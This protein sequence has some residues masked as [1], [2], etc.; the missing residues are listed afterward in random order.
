M[1]GRSR[2]SWKPDRFEQTQTIVIENLTG[3]PSVPAGEALRFASVWGL[4]HEH[5]RQ[6][7]ARRLLVSA[8]PA[9]FQQAS[10]DTG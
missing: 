6:G 3:A 5:H 2:F 9:F 1:P 8:G 7:Y 10:F 4:L